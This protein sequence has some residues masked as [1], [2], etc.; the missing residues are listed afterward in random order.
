LALARILEEDSDLCDRLP[1][2]QQAQAIAEGVARVQILEMG[3]WDEPDDPENHRDGFGLL[4]LDGML[5][6]RV[7]LGR[8]DCTELLGG[9][10]LL[11]PWSFASASLSSVS[12]KVTWNVV[13]PVR[14]AAL[15]R[16]FALSV[17]PWPEV[18]AA[19][20][21]R[22]IQ[23]SRWLAFQL[24]VCHVVRVDTRLL[25]MLWHFADRWGRMTK[26]GARVRIPVTH[27]VLAS[28]VGARRPSVTT[29]LGRLQDQGLIERH[30]D[31]EWLL[32]GSPPEDY[33]RIEEEATASYLGT[34]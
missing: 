32:I 9:G 12:S 7:T 33:A 18:A 20:M 11:R 10:D 19:L 14:F 34:D 5:A 2:D 13:E 4:V 25:L 30:A 3:M 6:R 24:A 21:D 23:R 31:G 15:D 26:D 28:V 27:S 1:A 22:I 17:A 29:A 8:F 16:R